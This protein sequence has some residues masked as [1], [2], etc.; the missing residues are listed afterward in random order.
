MDKSLLRKRLLPI[1][2]VLLL[3]AGCLTAAGIKKDVFPTENKKF[4]KFTDQLFQEEVSSNTLNLHYTLANPSSYGITDYPISLGSLRSEAIP[5]SYTAIENYQTKL[6]SYD[7]E[8]LSEEN[9]MTYDILEQ[10][11]STQL[12]L[13]DNYMLT[14]VLSPSL[15]IQAQLPV[16]LA[17]Y[18]FRTEQDIA[19]YLNLLTSIPKYFEEIVVFEQEKSEQGLFMSDTTVDR[20][21]EQ[22]N[23]FV[24]SASS[25]YLTAMFR[26][27]LE[28][29]A[30]GASAEASYQ[31]SPQD[32]DRYIEA[33]Q[34][35][36]D[37]QVFPAYQNLVKGLTA[38]KGTGKNPN[39]LAGYP[40]GV[41]YYTYLIR[42]D[43]GDFS[44]LEEIEQRL[45]KQ[46]L[47]DYQEMQ[48]LITAHP[49]LITQATELEASSSNV[50]ADVPTTDVPKEMLES[51]EKKIQTDFPKA[52]DTSYEIKYV[53]PSLEEFLSPAFYLTPPVDTQSPNVIYINN[54]T[55]S[56]SLEL[57][58]TLAHEGFPGHL[59]QTL[60]F[61][62]QDPSNIR[63][64][65][66]NS[67]YVEGWAT[68][69]ESYAYGY[70]DADPAVTRLLWLNR[71]VNLC[72]YSIMDMG[73]HYRGWTVD[74]VKEYLQEFGIASEEIASEI[75]QYIVENPANYL[76]Y[77]VGYLN[78]LDLKTEM[79]TSLGDSF[80][81]KEFHE[82]ILKLGPSQ[83]PVLKK[84]LKA[85]ML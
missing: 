66:S 46:L 48:Q 4:Q 2:P 85:E 52:A 11:F 63:Y 55:P 60:Y 59:Y 58:T 9:Q 56:S 18:T 76:K 35:V 32:I 57:F 78:F 75:F 62:Q 77:Y 71:S 3:S 22:C 19:D 41:E 67:G 37:T 15:G 49:D 47:A 79:Q 54:G 68:Y 5:A 70:A 83:F 24:E 6:H 39:G 61:V 30:S 16:L 13:G 80:N 51:L 53:H 25:N 33:H 31:P 40:N 65:L 34:K 81:L 69:V 64:L 27:K 1:L 23:A 45:Y 28:N 14:E 10:D 74:T 20:I 7:Y 21:A 26:E 8:K 44:S 38:L 84:Y 29:M 82:E 72:L 42:K 73:I 43:V 36:M 12:S 50:A 17:E